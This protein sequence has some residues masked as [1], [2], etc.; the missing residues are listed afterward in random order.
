MVSSGCAAATLTISSKYFRAASRY[1]N[2]TSGSRAHSWDGQA[3]C[4]SGADA[5]SL[6]PGG[7]AEVD[8]RQDA[9]P[10]LFFPRI[11]GDKR[12]GTNRHSRSGRLEAA[13]AEESRGTGGREPPRPSHRDGARV[14]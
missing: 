13:P 14:R 3:P 10:H 4:I 9:K 12:E 6:W 8:L 2:E 1:H 7:C 11:A 5:L